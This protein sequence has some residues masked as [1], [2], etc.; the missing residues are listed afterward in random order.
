MELE[1]KFGCFFDRDAD[2][3]IFQ[4]PMADGSSDHKVFKGEWAGL[5]IISR[6]TEQ[7]I[8]RGITVWE[9]CRAVE[10]LLDRTG[11]SVTG[12]LLFD[13]RRG[14]WIAV[15][16]AATLM[17]SG[18]GPTQYRFH[19]AGADKTMDGLGMMYRAGVQMRD[20]E[21][22]QFHPATLIV[23][24]SVVS[25]A[26]FEKGLRAEGAYLYNGLG[27]RFML[28]Y[29]PESGEGAGRDV[30]CRASYLEIASGRACP[31]GGIQMD[32]THL[33]A[34]W[35]WQNYPAMAKR[36]LQFGYD[37][38]RHR[39]PLAP[40]AQLFMG[41]AAIDSSCRSSLERLFVAGEDA[42]GVH[43]SNRHGGNSIAAACVFGRQAGKALAKY[44]S[45]GH[46]KPSETRPGQIEETTHLLS[47]AL[48]QTAGGC[49][50]ELFGN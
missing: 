8:K 46:G 27:E 29:A 34:D 40:S 41:G 35:V 24:G 4:K 22:I 17:A 49:P 10:L 43:G 44:L 18:G 32:A 36:F 30:L 50:I 15:E 2:G 16:A 25:G 48:R 3:K 21:M 23:S 14:S 26:L 5:E 45:N 33:G 19:A 20:M 39:I 38:G 31:E 28:R 9:E 12:A 13:V 1:N 6:L 11:E 42:G 47:Q 37:I 7:V